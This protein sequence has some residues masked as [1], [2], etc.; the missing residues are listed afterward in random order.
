VVRKHPGLQFDGIHLTPAGLR[1][2]YT[3]LADTLVA[4]LPPV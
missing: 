3:M 1:L 2:R 4:M